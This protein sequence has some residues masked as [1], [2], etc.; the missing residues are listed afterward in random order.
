MRCSYNYCIRSILSYIF[1]RS[2]VASMVFIASISLPLPTSRDYY[3]RMREN[4]RINNFPILHQPFISLVFKAFYSA[5]LIILSKL[6]KPSKVRY[7]LFI[8]L[9]INFKSFSV[10]SLGFPLPK[11][12]FNGPTHDGHPSSQPQCIIISSAVLIFLC[13]NQIVYR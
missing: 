11:N 8:Y 13:A 9:S 7:H 12:S 2:L 1:R 5:N 10:V 6:L 3:R 4:I